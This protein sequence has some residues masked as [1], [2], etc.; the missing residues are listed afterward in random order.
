M[1]FFNFQRAYS[2]QLN[3]PEFSS[4]HSLSEMFL[5]SMEYFNNNNNNGNFFK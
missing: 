5:R 4:F 1:S 3:R 2:F